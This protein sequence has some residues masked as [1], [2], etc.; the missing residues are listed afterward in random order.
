[1]NRG[2]NLFSFKDAKDLKI[3]ELNEKVQLLQSELSKNRERRR[4][5]TQIN[6]FMDK[7]AIRDDLFKSLFQYLKELIKIIGTPTPDIELKI[8]KEYFEDLFDKQVRIE[9]FIGENLYK[10]SF[11]GTM[12]EGREESIEDIEDLGGLLEGNSIRELYNLS[13]TNTLDIQKILDNTESKEGLTELSRVRYN[14][15]GLG[16][17][18]G[19]A[20]WVM[21]RHLGQFPGF[22]IFMLE[23]EKFLTPIQKEIIQ[24]FMT[25]MQPIINNKI[26]LGRLSEV[27]KNAEKIAY[28]DGLTGIPNRTQFNDDYMYNEDRNR[29]T[30]V[31]IDLCKLK[32]INDDHGHQVA[33]GVI[34]EFA[35]QIKKYATTY[36]GNA[37][38][39]G[40]D[41]FVA[42]LPP[43][44]RNSEI[45][46]GIQTFQDKYHETVFEDEKGI[47]FK[48]HASI[49][50]QINRDEEL[51]REEVVR[52]ADK[53]MYTSK[54][55]RQNYPIKYSWLENKENYEEDKSYGYITTE[56][57]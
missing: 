44:T 37:Y 50:V 26:S 30:V 46:E 15:T 6:N 48:T 55:D 7:S 42:V 3:E 47:K 17:Y 24:V 27:A 38:R 40:G 34:I 39:I 33:D 10:K 16:H 21:Q 25:I 57:G 31:Y 28:T 36:G 20:L 54:S 4:M 41:E 13:T 2:N 45:M 52:E 43:T 11:V 51:T 18:Q 9:F 1:M 49:G 29:C 14:R 5:S 35:N 32:Q 56:G 12:K 53:L 19:V 22:V 23:T 8:M